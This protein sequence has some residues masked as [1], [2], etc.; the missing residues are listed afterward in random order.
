MHVDH[1][2]AHS[3]GR[4]GF[5]HARYGAATSNAVHLFNFSADWNNLGAVLVKDWGESDSVFITGLKS[6][7]NVAGQDA[8]LSRGGP[9][10]QSNG[11]VVEDCSL[12]RVVVNGLSHIRVGRAN[13]APGPGITIEDTGNSGRRPRLS[14]SGV[15][16][17][18][19]GDEVGSTADAVTIRDTSSATTTDVSRGSSSGFYPSMTAPLMFA[20]L[21]GN[22][23]L[24]FT[25]QA[26]ATSHFQILNSTPGA[27]PNLVVADT[28]QPNTGM[29]L[30]PKGTGK[31][32]LKTV[33]SG[34]TP[35]IAA[36]GPD[37]NV[38]LDIE[39]RNNGVVMTRGVQ[40]EVKGHTHVASAVL[41]AVDY[42]GTWNAATNT[43]AL[44]TG[45]RGSMYQVSAAGITGV[46]NGGVGGHATAQI[47]TRQGGLQP[48][49]TLAGNKIPAGLVYPTGR[50]AVTAI[51]PADGWHELPAVNI[52]LDIL[53]TLAGVAGFLQQDISTN[54]STFYFVPF[55]TLSSDLTIPAGTPFICPDGDSL[56]DHINIIWF[57]PNCDRTN[58][59]AMIR[60]VDSMV[61]HLTSANKRFYLLSITTDTDDAITANTVLK[62]KYPTQWVDVRGYLSSTQALTDAGITATAAD[63][64]AIAKNYIPPSFHP[65]GGSHLTQAAYNVVGNFV[66]KRLAADNALSTGQKIACWGDS[67]TQGAL[68]GDIYTANP[69]YPQTLGS[70]LGTGPAF[71]AGDVVFYGGSAWAKLG[72]NIPWVVPPLNSTD[73][74]TAGQ[75]AYSTTHWYVCVKSGAAGS[76]LWKR[77]AYDT[78][79][80]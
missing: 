10:F 71:A 22:R 74:G 37:Q 41:G 4:Y 49:L 16:V 24:S 47:A 80:W 42:K 51:S 58:T 35:T 30:T 36:T 31:L 33:V 12:T 67:L 26:N 60:D 32:Y 66:A 54:N 63:T 52:A 55:N 7:G 44:T 14:Y 9:N 70:R 43:P 69:A 2:L 34:G 76:A 5:E 57:G 73:V 50:V 40:L 17:R 39:G 29:A 77:I 75:I 20:D 53:G 38:N 45:T 21:N 23:I 56:R 15:V 59:A 27:P 79:A 65:N 68:D 18:V 6:E 78:T 19:I 25:P 3:N 48:K 46:Y 62:A 8:D 64:A 13:T 28:A 11:I 1:C 72:G 61:A